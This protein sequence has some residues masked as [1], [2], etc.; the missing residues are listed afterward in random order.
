MSSK[1][2]ILSLVVVGSFCLLFDFSKVSENSLKI[3]FY[4]FV[5]SKC[6]HSTNFVAS[7]QELPEKF[8]DMIQVLDCRENTITCVNYDIE[9]TPKLLFVM[10]N[11]FF[12]AN[13]KVQKFSV[14][15]FLENP[16]R[17]GKLKGH[18]ILTFV[19]CLKKKSQTLLKAAVRGLQ[20][21]LRRDVISFRN[22]YFV[23]AF[24]VFYWI[25]LIALLYLA[26]SYHG[27]SMRDKEFDN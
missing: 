21:M 7:L 26:L 10:D 19:D 17:Q 1:M 22:P 6:E 25:G 27:N 20:R 5:Q 15:N 2:F 4:A 9:E 14:L 16:M 12:E 23:F 8:R 11:L 24:L 18:F 3:G 13:L